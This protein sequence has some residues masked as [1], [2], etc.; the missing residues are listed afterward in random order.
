VRGDCK[1]VIDVWNKGCPTGSHHEFFGKVTLKLSELLAKPTSAWHELLP[2]R[3][4][5]EVRWTPFIDGRQAGETVLL[6]LPEKNGETVGRGME[7]GKAESFEQLSLDQPSR[8]QRAAAAEASAGTVEGADGEAMGEDG[9]A[10]GE[11]KAEAAAVK[12]P[13]ADRPVRAHE[14]AGKAESARGSAAVAAAVTQMLKMDFYEYT[15]RGGSGHGPKEN[16]VSP[17]PPAD[18][19]DIHSSGVQQLR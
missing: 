1:L 7:G 13:A 14:A 17:Q 19:R 3:V 5:I 10:K 18:H 6:S 4:H 15:H 16:Q 2:G 11:G 8:G 9:A 12:A